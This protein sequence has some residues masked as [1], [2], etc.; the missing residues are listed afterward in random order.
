MRYGSGAATILLLAALYGPSA[1]AEEEPTSGLESP[2][3]ED[4]V[5]YGTADREQFHVVGLG[6]NGFLVVYAEKSG[7]EGRTWRLHLH[8]ADFEVCWTAVHPWQSKQ[9]FFAH[10]VDSSS[11]YLLLVCKNSFELLEI[12]R[13]IRN[14]NRVLRLIPR[15]LRIPPSEILR[16]RW[17]P[18]HGYL[19]RRTLEFLGNDQLVF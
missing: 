2:V 11:V 16:L 17:N 13:R 9:E 14:M 15:L 19:E 8:D 18:F 5:E 10:D 7:D 6:E 12:D 4:R 3:Q 1:L